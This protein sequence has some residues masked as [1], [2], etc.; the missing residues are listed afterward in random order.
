MRKREE[1]RRAN[2]SLSTLTE[3]NESLRKHV[4]EL[5]RNIHVLRKVADELSETGG[6]LSVSQNTTTTG[7]E[8]SS[9]ELSSA[10]DLPRDFLGVFLVRGQHSN[11]EVV[12]RLCQKELVG[13]IDHALGAGW[14]HATDSHIDSGM[15][16]GIRNDGV[17][18]LTSQSYVKPE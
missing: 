9:S 13:E 7:G 8:V 5:M 12:A 15:T 16:R 10:Y 4:D 2:T 6:D 18:N 1:S 14:L 17:L 3:Q 11:P